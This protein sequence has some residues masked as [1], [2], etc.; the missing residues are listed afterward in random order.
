[1]SEPVSIAMCCNV[2][3]DAAAVRG[4]LETSAPFFDNLF[5]VHSGPGGARSTDGTIEL[6]EQFGAT[7]VFDDM[8]RGFG[9]I[10]S[11]LIHDCGCTWAFILD[12]DERFHPFLP[13]MH[14]EGAE[15]FPAVA[16]PNLSTFDK[17]EVCAQGALLRELIAQP[18]L[19]AVMSIRRHW[20]D[21]TRRRPTQNWLR[22]PDHQL[23]IVR[24][25]P[26]IEYETGKVMH[27]RLLD[28]RTGGDPKHS[29]P[30]G[31]EGP[32]HDH[33]HCFFRNARPGSKEFNEQNYLRLERGEAMFPTD[34]K[35]LSPL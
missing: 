7:I 3:N 21:F 16:A 12:A 10:R 13:V 24:N 27:E 23:R 18:E 9:A 8:Q 34:S 4:L 17:D 26:E 33:Y 2:Y 19:M 15:S 11:R 14:C 35:L 5:F 6:I 22:I 31:Y 1:M 30:D 25:L 20:F 29:Q 32:F 28:T